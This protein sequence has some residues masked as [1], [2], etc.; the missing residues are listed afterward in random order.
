MHPSIIPL[1][2]IFRLNTQLI[3]NCLEGLDEDHAQRRW[4]TQLN[5]IAFLLAH[6]TETRHYLAEL[7]GQPVPSPFSPQFVKARSLEEAG[8]LPPLDRLV[9]AWEAI[10]AHLAS[11][12]ERIDTP[13]LRHTGAALPGSDGTLLE[14]LAFL[15]QHESYH[16]GQIALLRRGHGLPAMSY[17]LPAREPGRRGA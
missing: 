6:L 7:A 15:A 14:N 8:P 17:R 11:I 13:Q 16:L 4:G 1:A 12:L 3:L 9:Q 10:A 5:S 2:A